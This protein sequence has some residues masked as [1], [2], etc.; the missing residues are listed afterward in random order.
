MRSDKPLAESKVF[1]GQRL[2][3]TVSMFI[4]IGLFLS[5][6]SGA[7]VRNYIPVFEPRL[8]GV[9]KVTIN[10]D[11]MKGDLFGWML[12]GV[13]THREEMEYDAN[14]LIFADEGNPQIDM[15]IRMRSIDSGNF[16]QSSI[17]SFL[18][19]G[20]IHTRRVFG[21]ATISIGSVTLE[22]Y[23]EISA[24]RTYSSFGK[25]F[26]SGKDR[27]LYYEFVCDLNRKIALDREKITKKIQA[28]GAGGGTVM[29]AKAGKVGRMNIA[30]SNLSA[31][32]VSEG[33]AS[34]VADWLRGALVATGAYTVVERSAMQKVLAEQALQQTGCTDA[35][36]A[37]KLGKLLNV[38]RMVVG[39]FGKFLDSYVLNV[40]V[41]DVK[42]GE[43]VSSDTAKG[44][45]TDEIE[46]NITSLASRLAK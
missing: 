25:E 28:I 14:K 17:L 19:F 32:G 21:D 40:R 6:C 34:I 43:I 42:S 7:P 8:P 12:K 35:E 33:D 4:G 26:W 24:S 39:S 36:C 5:G 1:S 2:A 38:K 46:T 45:S 10:S 15:E 3:R 18:S 44:K 9:C 11:K 20:L 13:K 16:L 22:R 23:S 31:E 29:S 30:V 37:V 27:Q 41:V